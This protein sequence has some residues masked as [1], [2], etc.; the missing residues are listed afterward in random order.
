[1]KRGSGP[2]EGIEVTRA[3]VLAFRMA[4]HGLNR[5]T[6]EP[7]VGADLSLLDLGIQ[8]TGPD[9]A[10]W[11]LALRGVSTRGEGGAPVDED[12]WAMAWTLRGAPHLYRRAD[13]AAVA[14]ATAPFSETDA[15]KRIFDASKPLRDAGIPVLDALAT[16]AR[17]QRDLA[18]EPTAKGD[19][20]RE[21]TPRLDPP[22]LRH[23]RPCDTTH[24]Y[25]QP[26]RLSALQA[27]LELVPGTT[28][29]VLRRVPGVDPLVYQQSGAEA[30]PRFDVIRNH[31][32]FYGPASR[33]DLAQAIESPVKEVAAH[34]PADT[35]EVTITGLAGGP[36]S[37][38]VLAADLDELT[39]IEETR[40][41]G[42]VR[43]LGPYDPYL[44][45]RDRDLLVP[46]E[47]HRK[48]LWRV[49]GRPGAAVA[50]DGEV[51]ATWRPKTSGKRLT[52]RVGWWARPTEARRRA[53]TEAARMLAEHRGVTLAGVSEE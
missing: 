23:C 28:P 29:P 32:R 16:I 3:Q 19:V 38:T 42:A 31:L 50:D 27:G 52:V 49:L 8:D 39:S 26:F 13:L 18:A 41:E 36:R 17:H 14:L 6:D 46:D 15:A 37:A 5:P 53:L 44:Q 2:E 21:L 9:G 1:M 45:L 33:T 34:W 25:E 43:L 35:V 24:V 30:E 40:H 11:A 20:S 22:Y 7:I 48:D 12:E 4:R 51:L 47:A 10:P